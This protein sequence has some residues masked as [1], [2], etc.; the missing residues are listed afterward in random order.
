MSGRPAMELL[1]AF[2]NV[3]DTVLTAIGWVVFWYTWVAP[4]GHAGAPPPH[5]PSG[6]DDLDR[7]L[8]SA[9]A[10]RPGDG[11]A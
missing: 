6:A 3:A 8:R 9:A 11:L 2:L 5:S 1:N 4:P 7:F 10:K